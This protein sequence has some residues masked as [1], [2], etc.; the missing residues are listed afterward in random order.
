M[1]RELYKNLI[2]WKENNINMPYMLVGVRQTGKTYI[3][4][5]FC[6]N[7][8]EKNI[9]LNLDNMKNIRDVF[10]QTINPEEIINSI[11][12]ILNI[13]IDIEKTVIFIDEIQVSEKAINSLKYFCE[14]EKP[15]K[16]VCAGSLLGVKIN[17]FKTSFPVG[18]VWIDYLYPMNFSEFLKAI[19]ENKILKLIE[20][21]YS[22]MTPMVE[23]VHKKA[24]NLYFDYICL[25]GMPA[26]VLEYIKNDKNILK[27]NDDLHRIIITSY[28]ADMAKY[29]ENTESI[30]NSKIYNSIPAQLGKENKKFKFSL[31]DKSARSREYESSI[32]WLITSNMV[33]KCQGVKV[34]KSPLKV[35]IDDNFKLYLSDMGI[36][37]VLAEIEKSEILLEKNMI[38]KGVLAENYI[39]QIIYG[40]TR[41]L[42]YWQLGSEYEIDFLLNVDGD[43][44]PIEV[45]ASDNITSKSLNYYINR[46][47]PKYSIRISTK[48]FGFSNNIKS[49]PLYAAHLL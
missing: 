37:R 40:K 9:Y 44:I 16:I 38:Y 30:K 19:G 27:V 11:E 5:E 15:Y 47:K 10:E 33:L 34:P 20:K 32:D 3:L 49:I 8:F 48:N 17:R 29:T 6:K 18:K 46:Y 25:G 2:D 35:N 42:Y 45:K 36:L 21:C 22:T 39:A 41:N 28:L 12:A 43:I 26:I 13:E 31:V 7:E 4:S 14:S 1:E 24:L 23:S